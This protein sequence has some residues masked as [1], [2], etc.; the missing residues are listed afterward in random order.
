MSPRR[1]PLQ[2]TPLVHSMIV[3]EKAKRISSCPKDL[4]IN[5]NQHIEDLNRLFVLARQKTKKMTKRAIFLEIPPAHSFTMDNLITRSP[6]LRQQSLQISNPYIEI[7]LISEHQG[8][9]PYVIRR[10]TRYQQTDHP[11]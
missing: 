3:A 4:R 6:P 11:Q 7:D 5:K 10:L 1:P 9:L 8:C 2:K